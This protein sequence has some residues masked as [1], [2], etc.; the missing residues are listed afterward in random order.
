MKIGH[1]AIWCQ[2]LEEMK[3]FYTHFFNAKSNDIYENSSKGFRS[4]FLTLAD[5]PRIELMQMDAVLASSGDVNTQFTGPAHIAFSVGS[6][7][8]VEQMAATFI[9]NGYEVLDGHCILLNL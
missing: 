7:T 9:A 5:G 4:Y 6:E 3:H 8:K 2:N 1:V